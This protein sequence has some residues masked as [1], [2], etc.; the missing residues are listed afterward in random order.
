MKLPWRTRMI[1]LRSMLPLAVLVASF[2][3]C[4][5][6]VDGGPIDDDRTSPVP[7]P[8]VEAGVLDA[9][10]DGDD[11]RGVVPSCANVSW[12][13][14]ETPVTPIHAL[15][16]VW[17]ASKDDVWAVGSG[18]SIIH[19]DG[20][21]WTATPSGHQQTLYGVWGS[22]PNDIWVVSSTDLILHGTGFKDGAAAWEKVT[23][24]GPT[25]E[26]PSRRGRTLAVWGTSASD[27]RIGGSAFDF[28]ATAVPWEEW[29]E[30]TDFLFVGRGNQLVKRAANDVAVWRPLPG[31]HT[32]KSIWGSSA[33][34]VW[35][36]GEITAGDDLGRGVTL[37]GR[38]YGGG[39]P[40]PNVPAN[41]DLCL[42]CD[43]GCSGCAIMDD[44]L[45]WTVVDSQTSALLES[46]WGSSASDVWAV[47][48]HGT[49]RRIQT[50]DAR[51]QKIESPTTKTLHGVWGS[52]PNDIW[53]VGDD[54]TIL[55]FDGSKLEPSSVQL[56]VGF[57][58]HLRGV[59]GSGPND[60]WIVGDGVVLRY[61][62]PK[63]GGDE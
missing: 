42:N 59:W 53:M 2:A 30:S 41:A 28:S 49:I 31:R 36:T 9:G 40:H 23:A 13:M 24:W 38:P 46:V 26:V 1:A 33:T 58:P 51:W 18:G 55:H 32:I 22:G 52:G 45:E 4:A 44:A 47:G 20:A 25:Y 56:P 5:T 62:G 19:F 63:A 8:D 3:S 48:V 34:D 60:V 16:S 6:N 7:G 54:A 14:V 37:H 11:C 21:V 12:C 15:T 50:G 29:D 61:S 39:R 17:G 57:K 43:P 10:C 27:V 35:M